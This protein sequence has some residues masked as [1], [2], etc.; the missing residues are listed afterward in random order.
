[1]NE[2]RIEELL[3]K[4]PRV[5]APAGLLEKLNADISLPRG[6]IKKMDRVESV[7]FFRRWFPAL[8]FGVLVLGCL[9]TLAVQTKQFVE[10]RRENES[11]RAAS[12]NLD[13]LRQDNAELQRLRSA[14]QEMGRLQKDY[15]NLLRLRAEV[16]QLRAQVQELGTLRTENERLKAEHA[17][18]AAKAG[19]AAE[20]DPIAAV[21]EKANRIR[22]VNN[23]KQ[24]GLAARIW[25][26]GRREVHPAD[27]LIMSNELATPKILVCP[28][29]S[30]RKAA[31]TWQNFNNANLSYEMV[32]PGAPTTEPD[33]VY[34]RCPFHNTVCMVDGSVQ[35]LGSA[36]KIVTVDGKVKIAKQEGTP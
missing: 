18:A 8:P 35:T 3:R 20:E 28:S 21:K 12:A 17:A 32:S 14:A 26:N 2:L 24:I 22:C 9:I 5:S 25:A 23:L 34:V 16:A 36:W 27:F 29:D 1:M 7:A 19:V 33:V 15:E 4:A 30:V 10:L 13:Q 11:L 31:D 6:Q